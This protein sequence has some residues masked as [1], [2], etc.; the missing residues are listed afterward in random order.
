MII[1]EYVEGTSNNKA[2]EFYN[3]TANTLDLSAY[4]VE[5]Y[6]NGATKATN[7]QKLT[8]SLAPGAVL[9]LV[10]GSAVPEL[11]ARGTVSSVT[12]F[13]GDDAIVLKKSGVVI[14]SFGQVGVQSMWGA[15]VTLRRKSGI[16]SG[17][18]NPNDPFSAATEWDSFPVDTF[19]GL[20]SR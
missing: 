1:S 15:D 4:T 9:V 6:A 5:L 18:S 20:G 19:D 10:N 13:N 8:G 16:V 11:K 7:T 3:P 17:D 2:L 14:D 12:N